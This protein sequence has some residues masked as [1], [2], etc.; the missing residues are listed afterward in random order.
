MYMYIDPKDG[1]DK[2]G[3]TKVGKIHVHQNYSSIESKKTVF[4]KYRYFEKKK[5]FDNNLIKM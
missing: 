5:R 3:M 4:T 2:L 1:T